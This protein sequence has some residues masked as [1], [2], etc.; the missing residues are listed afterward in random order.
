[1]NPFSRVVAL[2]NNPEDLDI[3]VQALGRAGYSAIPYLFDL[4]KFTPE[5]TKPCA[6][7]RLI[8]LTFI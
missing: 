7:L 2:D 6:G 1:M 4:A 8:F 3:I 5:I